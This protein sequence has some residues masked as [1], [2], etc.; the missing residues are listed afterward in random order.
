MIRWFVALALVPV[1]S[2][3]P[4]TS[5][6]QVTLTS[7]A[8]EER[9]AASGESYSGT[10][11]L[12]NTSGSPQEVRVYQTDYQFDADG[13]TFYPDK[14]TTVRSNAAWI[15]VSPSRLVIPPGAPATVSYRVAVPAVKPLRGTYWSLIM[16][17]II[18]PG[19]PGSSHKP[20]AGV[21][22]QVAIQSRTRYAVQVATHIS[23]TGMRKVEFNRPTVV[24]SSAGKT[25]LQVDVINSGDLAS[26]PEISLELYDERGKLAGKF[27]QQRGLLYPGSSL[28]QRFELG[29][30]RKGAY[31]ALVTVDTG[32]QDVFGAQYKLKF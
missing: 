30:V 27:K 10:V 18:P 19:T 28:R 1:A 5:A 13:R 14:G 8:V 25:S 29:A 24:R 23:H 3:T 17:E 26:R 12:R 31:E 2:A 16:A 15:T 32:D 7:P 9:E 6:A 22:A 4:R 20:A 21:R 11:T